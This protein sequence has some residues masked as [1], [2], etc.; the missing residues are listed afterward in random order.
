MSS[1]CGLSP[2]QGGAVIL[3]TENKVSVE[4]VK[5]PVS[6]PRVTAALPVSAGLLGNPELRVVLVFGYNCCKVGASSYLQRVVSTFG[7]LDVIVAGGQV[8][9]LVSLTSGRYVWRASDFSAVG[10]VLRLS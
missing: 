10:S 3:V 1:G 7:G 5:T 2:S 6:R 8:D 9:N 4:E